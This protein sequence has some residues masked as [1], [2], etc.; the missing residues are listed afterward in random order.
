MFSVFKKPSFDVRG[1]FGR[2][3]FRLFIS[4]R[5]GFVAWAIVVTI[6]SVAG[7]LMVLTRYEV[8]K[9]KEE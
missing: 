8:K 9:A 1:F 4:Y 6:G 7:Y 3:F 2:F 5:L